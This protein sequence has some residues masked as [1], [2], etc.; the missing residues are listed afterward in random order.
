MKPLIITNSIA[1]NSNTLKVW[2][3]LVNP[4]QTKK[5]MFGCETVSDWKEGSTLDWKGSYNGKEMTFVTGKI[6]KIDPGKYLAYTTFDPNSTMENIPENHLKVTYTLSPEKGGTMLTVTQG[7]Y[8]TVAEGKKR[9]EESYNN[10]EGWNPIL[11]EIKKL[12][13]AQ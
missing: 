4:G 5:Y 9:Y 8:N 1:I 7:D 3:A 6:V 11:V 2:D 12:T 10:G 13:E